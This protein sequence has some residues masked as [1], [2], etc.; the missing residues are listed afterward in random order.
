MRE[1]FKA[2]T[3]ITIRVKGLTFSTDGFLM[4]ESEDNKLKIFQKIDLETFPSF[5]DFSGK[6]IFVSEN[7]KGMILEYVGRPSKINTDPNF[8]KYDVYSVLIDGFIG[9]IFSQNL[10][11]DRE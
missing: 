7:Q 9:Q 8:F 10:S 2:G 6:H 1:K 3:I 11:F 4:H 5:G